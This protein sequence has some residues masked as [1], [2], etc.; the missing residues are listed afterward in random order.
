MQGDLVKA[1]EAHAK[2]ERE[3]CLH[4]RSNDELLLKMHAESSRIVE[5]L[6]ELKMKDLPVLLPN[7]S[8]SLRYYPSFLELVDSLVGGIKESVSKATLKAGRVAARQVAAQFVAA[9]HHRCLQPP[10]LPDLEGLTPEMLSDPE[11][12][13]QVNEI[14]ECLSR[15][16]DK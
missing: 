7:H 12:T 3:F 11:V 16:D 2:E 8:Y 13:R 14:M 10:S 6:A 9:L 15:E 4:R 5:V 1:K